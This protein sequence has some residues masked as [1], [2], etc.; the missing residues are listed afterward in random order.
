M[1]T[2]SDSNE[3]RYFDALKRIASYLDPDKLRRSAQKLYGCTE[4]EALEMSYENVLQEAR[5]AAHGR[6][7]PK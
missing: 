5:A 2:A 1:P 7:R 3:R 6:R 4:E